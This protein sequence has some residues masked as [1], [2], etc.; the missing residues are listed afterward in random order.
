MSAERTGFLAVH[1]ALLAFQ[2]W[3]W[4]LTVRPAKYREEK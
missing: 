1:M 2:V 4:W 3:L